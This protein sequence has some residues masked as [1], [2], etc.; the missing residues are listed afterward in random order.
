MLHRIGGWGNSVTGGK[1]GGQF[2]DEPYGRYLIHHNRIEDP[3]LLSNDWGG[4]ETWQGGSHYVW[5][6][7]SINP[8][9]FRYWGWND[10]GDSAP[11][12][13]HA[14]Y[15]DGAF[16]N[17]SFNNIAVGKSN[18]KREKTAAEAAFQEIHGFQN[19]IFNNT[20]YKFVNATRRQAPG[21]GRNKYLGNVFSDISE[22]VFYHATPPEG[23]FDPNAHHFDQS[24]SFNHATGAY[25]NNVLH[26]VRKHLGVFE[27][28]RRSLVHAGLLPRP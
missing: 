25:A 7:V 11:R 23:G 17:F 26:A 6:N 12:F 14:Y 10:R 5:S 1:S 8:G 24:Q 18:D 15:M 3:L 13:G 19:S 2:S 9:G 22:W 28:H 20:A 4:I 16:K 21:A 27:S